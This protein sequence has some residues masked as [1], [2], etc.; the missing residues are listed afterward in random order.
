MIFICLFFSNRFQQNHGIIIEKHL[1]SFSDLINDD[2]N[3]DIIINCSGL[4]S[5]KLCSDKYLVPIRGQV[6]KVHAPWLKIG[7][8][9][10]YDTYI[11]PGFE[12]VTLGGCRNYDSYNMELCKYDSM[13]IRERCFNMLPSLKNA[14][15]IRESVGL[16]PHRTPV[17]VE[18]DNYETQKGDLLKIIHNY[19]HGGYGV[20]TSPGTAKY[21]VQLVKTIWSSRNYLQFNSKL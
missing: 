12:G 3:Y 13:S 16:R 8:Y 9:G 4:G 14:K 21:V 17:R 11:I 18:I 7:F 20:T 5:Q 19:G 2:K 15:I 6:I 1:N 10:D